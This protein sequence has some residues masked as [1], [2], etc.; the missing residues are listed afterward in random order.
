MSHRCAWVP[1]YPDCSLLSE[2]VGISGSRTPP[3]D[4]RKAAEKL[5]RAFDDFTDIFLYWRGEQERRGSFAQTP[6]G[7]KKAR[8]EY[9]DRRLKVD[10][11]HRVVRDLFRQFVEEE[12]TYDLRGDLSD[13]AA[14]DI[15]VDY[16]LRDWWSALTFDDALDRWANA[17]DD[18][19]QPFIERQRAVLRAFEAWSAERGEA[20]RESDVTEAEPH[21]LPRVGGADGVGTTK[22]RAGVSSARTARAGWRHF[23]YNPYVVSI[24]VGALLLLLGLV[25]G[26]R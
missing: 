1:S 21:D 7:L 26:V 22:S 10:S 15:P 16:P 23:A 19:L 17:D 5:R 12:P 2:H 9:Q 11:A 6:I 4:A 13:D 3:G 20:R 25:F 18:H 14:A 24:S 8:D